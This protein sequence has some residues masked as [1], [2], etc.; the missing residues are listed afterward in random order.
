MKAYVLRFIRLWLC[1]VHELYDVGS[2]LAVDAKNLRNGTLT[3][4]MSLR[5]CGGNPKPS[6]QC[7]RY[8]HPLVSDHCSLRSTR[9]FSTNASLPLNNSRH[10]VLVLW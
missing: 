6:L 2:S 1:N 7:A 8:L 4:Q 9:A 5:L 10:V 3:I